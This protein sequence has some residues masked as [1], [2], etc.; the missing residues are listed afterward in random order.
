MISQS[1]IMEKMA[2]LPNEMIHIMLE[3]VMHLHGHWNKMVP[4]MKPFVFPDLSNGV[5]FRSST[6]WSTNDIWSH[7]LFH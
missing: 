4:C 2:T 3:C 7:H 5:K 6:C 1:S